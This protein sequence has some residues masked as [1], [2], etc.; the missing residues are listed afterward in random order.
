MSCGQCKT[1]KRKKK[2]RKDVADNK[3][4]FW[5]WNFSQD[6][7]KTKSS[8][9]LKKRLEEFTEKKKFI[10]G[11]CIC[12]NCGWFRDSFSKKDLTI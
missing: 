3:M 1:K 7:V 10:E 12:R 9:K 8:Q 6:S 4:W 5:P 11:F 2:M